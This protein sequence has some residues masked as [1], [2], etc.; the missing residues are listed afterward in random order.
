MK[1]SQKKPN[2]LGRTVDSLKQQ[3]TGA[4]QRQFH[5]GYRLPSPSRSG[6]RMGSL[7]DRYD[8]VCSSAGEGAYQLGRNGTVR[9]ISL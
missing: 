4:G 5:S 8:S 7:V 2:D 3:L 9:G 6:A 1:S